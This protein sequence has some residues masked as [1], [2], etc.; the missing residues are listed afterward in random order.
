[1]PADQDGAAGFEAFRQPLLER[2]G[3]QWV[4]EMFRRHRK[5]VKVPA[6]AAAS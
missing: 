1:M 2:R 4:K 6:A 5:P 3:I